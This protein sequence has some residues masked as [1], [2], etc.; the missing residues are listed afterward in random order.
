MCSS[1]QLN[2]SIITFRTIPK[3]A[4]KKNQLMKEM[5]RIIG[6]KALDKNNS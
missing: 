4:S 1:M 6:L 5:R 3:A 2:E